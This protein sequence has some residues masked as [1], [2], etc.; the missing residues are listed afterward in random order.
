MAAAPVYRSA[1]KRRHC[2]I[3]VSGFYEWDQNTK[4]KIPHYIFRQDGAPMTFAGLW[5]S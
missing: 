1:Y 2:V 4:P 5:E 3:P